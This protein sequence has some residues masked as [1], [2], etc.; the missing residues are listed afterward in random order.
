MIDN[1]FEREVIMSIFDQMKEVVD[2]LKRLLDNPEPG[3]ATW[4]MHVNDCF[5]GIDR[6]RQLKNN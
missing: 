5:K 6:I 2:I 3:Y 1:L 4:H